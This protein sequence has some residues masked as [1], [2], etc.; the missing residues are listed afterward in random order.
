VLALP[1]ADDRPAR[2]AHLALRY[3]AVAL[4]PPRRRGGGRLP[5]VDVDAV[6]VE[7]DAA[8]AGQEPVRWLLL[9][10]VP[11]ADVASAWER[12][13]WYTYRWR[14]ERYHLVLKSGLRIEQRQLATAA[15]LELCLAVCG[16]VASRLLRLTYLARVRPAAP[17][18]CVLPPD[19]WPVL[20]A[21][22]HPHAPAPPPA[23]PTL[24]QAVREI[25]A[26]GGFLGRRGDGDPGVITLW[27][28][29]QR[30]QDLRA[31]Y[32]LATALPT[33]GNG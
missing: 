13:T 21:A 4:V 9:T 26:L 15:R 17:A 16:V 19:A 33:V 31:G 12:V 24:R 7:E 2:D 8:P 6:L 30:L 28:G 20:W 23:A 22:R 32:H 11:V 27:R 3:A 1:R 10:S 5:P 18:A 25:A 29:W 14:V